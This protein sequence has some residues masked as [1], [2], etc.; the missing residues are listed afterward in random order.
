MDQLK[1]FYKWLAEKYPDIRLTDDDKLVIG[2]VIL[3]TDHKTVLKSQ[4]KLVSLGTL[5]AEYLDELHEQ[6][7]QD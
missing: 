3:L 4:K 1:G 2:T 6:D 7:H 5:I